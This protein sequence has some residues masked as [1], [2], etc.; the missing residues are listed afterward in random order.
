LS[1]CLRLGVRSTYVEL[2]WTSATRLRS[3]VER[4]LPFR[5]RPPQHCSLGV[6][7]RPA[8]HPWQPCNGI[9]ARSGRQL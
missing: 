7:G 2:S 1:W 8:L 3:R 9:S 6:L 4:S 5:C